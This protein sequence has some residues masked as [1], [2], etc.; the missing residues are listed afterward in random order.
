MV[1]AECIPEEWIFDSLVVDEDQDFDQEWLEILMLFLRDEA[2]VLWLEDPD[3]NLHGKPSVVADGFVGY[4]RQVN[5][6]SPESITRFIRN[7]LPFDFE[8][9]NG[10]SGMK[11]GVHGYEKSEKQPKSVAKIVQKLVRR[12]FSHDDMVI[13]TCR[14]AHNS[15]FSEI[16]QVGGIRLRHF[17]GDYDIQGN[18]ILTDDQLTFDSIYRLKGQEASA[19]ILVDVDLQ[20]DRIDRDERLLYCDMTR[21][22]V[23]L[24]MVVCTGNPENHRFLKV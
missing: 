9:G 4:Q 20:T 2:D 12:G 24:D 10:L 23:R 18:Q 15:V 3:Q 7:T 1:T 11:V 22:T 16:E 8:V 5:C 14:G 19:V 13:I 6:R 21:A 17:T